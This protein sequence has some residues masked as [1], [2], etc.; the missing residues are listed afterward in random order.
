MEGDVPFSALAQLAA[1]LEG[2][3]ARWVVGGSTG[4]VLRGA[5]LERAPR[6]ID[7]YVDQDAVPYIHARLSP[8]HL[9]GPEDN[10]TDRY[11]SIL[12]HY[13]IAGTMVELVGNFRVSALQSLY[14]TEV[15]D[16]L[17]AAS[18]KV[19]LDGHE[20]PLVP[21]GHELLF[22]LLRERK[23]RAAVAGELIAKD[24]EKQLPILQA[25]IQRNKLSPEISVEALKLTKA[26]Y[27]IT[28]TKGEKPQW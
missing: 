15:N 4:L 25:L 7:V 10:Q 6:D 9:D 5:N 28:L 3:E 27:P 8:Y 22:N 26:D 18:D 13:R 16:F 24:C 11:H 12:S 20:I 19:D 17:F 23:D 21:L 1:S 14:V 2:C